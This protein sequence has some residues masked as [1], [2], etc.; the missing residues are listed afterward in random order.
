[1]DNKIL[2][3]LEGLPTLPEGHAWMV[4]QSRNGTAYV[5]RVVRPGPRGGYTP[6]GYAN[7]IRDIKFPTEIIQEEF[8]GKTHEYLNGV[9]LHVLNPESIIDTANYV[10]DKFMGT[11][12]K[13][14]AEEQYLGIFPNDGEKID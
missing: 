12:S 13:E 8:M 5:I 9:A 14:R 2:S 4:E 7:V 1:M 6:T 10:F 11:N 3:P